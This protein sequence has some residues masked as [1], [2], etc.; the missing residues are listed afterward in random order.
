MGQTP[1]G[2]ESTTPEAEHT[3]RQARAKRHGRWLSL[4]ALFFAL[5]ALPL[6]CKGSVGA[7]G[8]SDGA[9]STSGNGGS[10][11][12]AP[13]AIPPAS[14]FPRLDH[15]QYDHTVQ[16]LF[17][18]PQL[19]PS[20]SLPPEAVGSMDDRAWTGYKDSAATLAKTAI[21]TAAIRDFILPCQPSGDGAACASQFISTFGARAF[22]RP[23]SAAEQT[24][25][26]A[27]YAGRSETTASGS[28]DE[29]IE[30]ILEGFLQSPSFL[31][32]AELSTERAGDNI[33][34][35]PYEV[36]SRLS[37]AL[38]NSMPDAALFD[39]AAKNELSTAAQIR[40]QAER[41]LEQPR[42]REMVK[43]FHEHYLR[44]EGTEGARW[45]DFVRDETLFPAFKTETIPY[46]KEET[47]RFVD[48]IVFEK[49]AGFQALMTDNTAF[50]N[51][52]T[53]PLYGLDGS[54]YGG[55][56]TKA[57]LDPKQ[58]AGLFTR[59]GFLASHAQ[60]VR[61]SPIL[62][63][64]LIQ[65]YVLCRKIGSP[66]A[67]AE[68][69]PLPE[70]T[71]DIVTTRQRVTLQT[72]PDDCN[73]CHAIINPTGFPFEHYDAVGSW[74]TMDT[75]K[76]VDSTGTA[77]F[78]DRKISYEGPVDFSK[79]LGDAPEAHGCY[80]KNWVEFAFGRRAQGIDLQII[81]SLAKKMNAADYTILDMLVDIVVSETFRSR[82]PE[83]Q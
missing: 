29:G 38:W 22:R 75:G 19:T 54:G 32:R 62:R 24:R 20:N 69:T 36:A 83:A 53:A 11:T 18:A 14:R 79:A 77:L 51:N 63:G 44:M 4:A 39:A 72:S 10:G 26:E 6:G 57:T 67:G 25:F 21:S 52:L 59:V 33:Q 27:L 68:M 49:R 8:G 64:A 78:G 35:N 43:T 65:K 7:A 1:N 60:V 61:T 74:Q 9:G 30:L 13:D 80:A 56:L 2:A 28:F 47:L 55:E 46:L 42:A 17:N 5:G 76:P 37:Y 71:P 31:S 48:Y 3:G 45:T 50:V 15:T 81:D 23:L 40:A 66:P 58:R 16:D 73:F 12:V 82:A 41:M 34:L 70:V